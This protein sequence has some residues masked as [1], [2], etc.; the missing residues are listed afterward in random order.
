MSKKDPLLGTLKV[1][2]LNLQ[3]EGGAVTDENPHLSSCCQL[4]EIILRKG[5]QQTVLGLIRRDYWHWLEQLPQ[6]DPCGKLSPVSMAVEKTASCIKVLTSQGRGRYFLRLA[7]NRRILGNTV[8]H[9]LHTP[10]FSE[11]YDPA[12]SILRNEEFVEPFLSLLLV[13]SEMEFSL[14]IEVCQIYETVPCRELGM[15]LRYLGKRVFVLEL[16]EGSQAQVDQFVLPGDI[17]DEINGVSLRNACNGLAGVVLQRLKGQPLTFRLIRWCSSDGTVYRPMV[18][19][20]KALQQENP[21]FQL[22]PKSQAPSHGGETQ[23]LRDGRVVYIVQYLGKADVGMY[24]G[25]EVLQ[26]GIP[27]VLEQK[28]PGKVVLFDLKETHVICTEKSSKQELFQHHYPD[29]S[30]VGRYCRLD[31]TVFAFCVVDCQKMPEICSFSCVVM[32][33]SSAK[34]CE[35]IVN[36]I[37]TGFKHTEWFV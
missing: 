7:L 15:V 11:W 22:N 31:Q 14:N 30:C 3:S 12:I 1:C 27:L 8:H 24:G 34:D 5:L 6:H 28:N 17:I 13:L 9:F 37:A 10:K 4:L 26:Q 33:A 20:L 36:R 21:K 2:I 16:V 35:E 18:K 29:I 19:L 25:K 32:Q 23:C